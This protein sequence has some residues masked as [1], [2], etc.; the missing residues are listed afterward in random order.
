MLDRPERTT[1]FTVF[2]V[3]AVLHVPTDAKVAMAQRLLEKA[4]QICLVTASL[5]SEIVL[6][7]EVLID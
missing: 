4:E 3:H 6:T 7:T 5:K 2:N 1:F